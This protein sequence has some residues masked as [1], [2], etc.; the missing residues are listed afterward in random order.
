MNHTNMSVGYHVWD[1]CCNAIRQGR[2]LSRGAKKGYAPP[3]NV[4]C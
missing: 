2:D 1:A 3:R 4:E